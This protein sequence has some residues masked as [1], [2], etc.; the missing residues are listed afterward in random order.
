MADKD[1][2]DILTIVTVTHFSPREEYGK[3]A[4]PSAGIVRT[5]TRSVREN[6]NGTKRCKHV[7]VYNEPK[8]KNDSADS[9]GPQKYCENL[10]ELSEE[11]SL[12][13][14]IRPNDGLRSALLDAF[15]N[16]DTP[17]TMFVEHDW[18][19]VQDINIGSIIRAFDEY[20]DINSIRF[21]KRPNEESLWD[22][23]VEEDNSKSIPLC[24][25]STVGN[26]P[27]IVRTN[28]F[29]NWVANSKPTLPVMVQG[30]WHHY[31]T[32]QS[33]INYANAFLKKYLLKQDV[34][35]KFDNVEFVLD[36]K[37]KKQ[38]SKK[39]FNE[40]HSDWGVYMYGMRQDGPYVQHLGR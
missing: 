34:V 11:M 28:V 7:L 36:T 35:G 4:P 26:H 13:L 37:Y 21:N 20:E 10:K 40:A 38:I 19:F 8:S 1:L 22:T 32:P 25:T 24:R 30:V 39:G 5:T 2:E 29:K 33:A 31:S 15:S 14:Y 3:L 12:D 6:L 9:S 18:E 17:L 27:Q 23:K 16:V